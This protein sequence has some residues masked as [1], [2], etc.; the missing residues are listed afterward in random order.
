MKNKAVIIIILV[1]NIIIQST[2]ISRL[3]VFGVWGNLSIAVIVALSIGFGSYTGGYS[4]LFIGLIEDILFSPVIGTRALIYFI[5]GFLIGNTEAG[6]NKEDVRSGIIFTMAATAFYYFIH[7]LL[8]RAIGEAFN[9]GQY[10]MGPL[11]IEILINLMLY[12]ICFKLFN[13]IFDYPRFR[14]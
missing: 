3:P 10:L 1:A 6:I 9:M 11:F 7:F 8:M 4:G 14:L 13:R 2:L 12:I 5:I